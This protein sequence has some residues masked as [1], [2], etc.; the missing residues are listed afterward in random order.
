[1]RF[2]VPGDECEQ[3]ADPEDE[4][5]YTQ[6]LRET[7]WNVNG[8]PQSRSWFDAGIE[9]SVMYGGELVFIKEPYNQSVCFS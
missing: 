4:L 2:T 3:P 7:S 5:I 6:G 9:S 1:M 8:L